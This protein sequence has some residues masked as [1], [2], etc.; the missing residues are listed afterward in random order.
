MTDNKKEEEF[1]NFS[2]DVKESKPFEF[3]ELEDGEH[4]ATIKKITLLP[5]IHGKNGDF[6]MLKWYFDV[7]GK[8]IVGT[9]AAKLTTMSKSYAWIKA[10]TGKEPELNKPFSPKTLVGKSCRIITKNKTET[11]EFCG[12]KQE[13]TKPEVTDVMHTKKVN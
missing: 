10:I 8:E 13:V 7:E 9:S 2:L 5:N 12:Q 4:S 6:D 1:E 11:K 3:P